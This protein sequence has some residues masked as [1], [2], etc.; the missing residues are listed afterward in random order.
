MI[1][2]TKHFVGRVLLC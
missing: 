1:D 2:Q